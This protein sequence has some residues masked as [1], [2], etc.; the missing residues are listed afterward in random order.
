MSE[1]PSLDKNENI[2]APKRKLEGL[3]IPN[4]KVPIK[5]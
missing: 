5:Q 1:R 2:L 4:L 3:N